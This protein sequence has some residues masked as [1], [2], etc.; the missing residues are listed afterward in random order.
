MNGKLVLSLEAALVQAERQASV[1]FVEAGG[2]IARARSRKDPNLRDPDTLQKVKEVEERI[3]QI[4]HLRRGMLTARPGIHLDWPIPKAELGHWADYY[5]HCLH[6]WQAASR[7]V[8]QVDGEALKTMGEMFQQ[9]VAQGLKMKDV[10]FPYGTFIVITEKPF[11]YRRG[12]GVDTIIFSHTL[13]GDAPEMRLLACGSPNNAGLRSK[14]MDRGWRSRYCE[15]MGKGNLVS[16]LDMT[17]EHEDHFPEVYLTHLQ[18]ATREAYTESTVAGN[19]AGLRN[20]SSE[21]YVVIG[22]AYAI[23]VSLALVLAEG[24]R[25]GI[26]LHEDKPKVTGSP[27]APPRPPRPRT[28][29]MIMSVED[30]CVV[31][32]KYVVDVK[33]AVE[34]RRASNVD[35]AYSVRYHTRTYHY[36]R[37]PNDPPGVKSIRVPRVGDVIEVRVDR[38]PDGAVQAGSTVDVRI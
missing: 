9:A 31:T 18:G 35:P 7:R 36:R 1:L 4:A 38:K 5:V 37:G 21:E 2:K 29:D 13:D 32:G 15:H 25:E 10:V 24:K 11:C 14:L 26:T 6:D 27:D 20:K 23:A 33:A 16:G 17:R 22:Q 8:F 28:P 30:V 34:R 19:L 3:R 12:Q